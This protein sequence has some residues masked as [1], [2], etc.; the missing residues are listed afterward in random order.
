M[1][2]LIPTSLNT[3]VFIV[4]SLLLAA[5]SDEPPATLLKINFADAKLPA[6]VAALS[7]FSSPEPWGR[8]SDANV[9]PTAKIQFKKPLPKDF[10]LTVTG[11]AMPNNEVAVVK[12]GSFQDQIELQKLGDSSTI[13]VNLD[14]PADTI[15]IIPSEPVSPKKLGLNDDSR[16]L[17]VGLETL[18]IK[19]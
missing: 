15:E 4:V 17:G 1:N 16:K 10:A 19:Q 5:C 3:T 6:A 7:G 11:Q 12:I 9:A 2:R 8:W 13:D 18:Q 14:Q